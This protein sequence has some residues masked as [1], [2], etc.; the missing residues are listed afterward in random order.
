MRT[1]LYNIET[2]TMTDYT[3]W[4]A[5]RRAAKRIS[6][7]TGVTRFVIKDGDRIYA[8]SVAPKHCGHAG[9]QDAIHWMPIKVS[10]LKKVLKK[11]A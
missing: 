6:K 8:S 5:A 10:E 9:I 4:D 1:E 3:N 11:A 2:N 7:E